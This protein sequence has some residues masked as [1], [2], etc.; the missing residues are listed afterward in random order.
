[1]Y[2][3]IIN[4]KWFNWLGLNNNVLGEKVGYLDISA[5]SFIKG[6]A[7]LLLLQYSNI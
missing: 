3:H 7:V 1:M 5:Y 2:R 6:S 4:Q